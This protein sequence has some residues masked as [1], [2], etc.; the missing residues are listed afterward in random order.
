MN[1]SPTP[2]VHQA[3]DNQRFTRWI[4][5]NDELFAYL[6]GSAELPVGDIFLR[7]F[8]GDFNEDAE[9]AGRTV[10]EHLKEL[11]ALVGPLGDFELRLIW[12][13][14]GSVHVTVAGVGEE[15]A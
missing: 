5:D 11:K 1:I 3:N 4:E 12:S 8:D 13:T 9:K 15:L 2:E 14:D 7:A 6:K 10:H